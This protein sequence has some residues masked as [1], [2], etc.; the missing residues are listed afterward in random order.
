MTQ[1]ALSDSLS[2]LIPFSETLNARRTRFIASSHCDRRVNHLHR[3]ERTPLQCLRVKG[4]NVVV[5]CIF[6]QRFLTPSLRR[7]K[8]FMRFHFIDNRSRDAFV[9]WGDSNSQTYHQ[10]KK[11]GIDVNRGKGETG[12][13]IGVARVGVVGKRVGVG[14][15]WLRQSVSA[16]GFSLVLSDVGMPG[17]E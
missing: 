8:Q 4:A 10:L 11:S 16:W 5:A 9:T 17:T 2:R 12:R 15:C 6:C 3:S 7:T 14:A 13:R 1:Q